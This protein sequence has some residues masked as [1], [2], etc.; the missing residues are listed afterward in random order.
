MRRMSA[1]LLSN[2]TA[3][4]PDK[5]LAALANPHRWQFVQLLADGRPRSASAVAERFGR[6]FDGVSKHLRLLRSA[7]VLASRRG[8]DRRQELFFLPSIFRVRDGELDFGFCVFRVPGA[9]VESPEPV[10]A[11]T[12][13]TPPPA[14]P[15]SAPPEVP[16]LPFFITSLPLAEEVDEDDPAFEEPPR[17]FGEMLNQ[18]RPFRF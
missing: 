16:K 5:V 9:R 12:P 6:D 8:D 11:Q 13:V 2:P 4:N 15:V 17:G 3:L 7:G 18:S 14:K 1:D 10:V